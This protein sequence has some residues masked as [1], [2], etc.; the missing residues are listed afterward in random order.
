MGDDLVYLDYAATAGRRPPAVAAAIADFLTNNGTTPGRGGHRL[1]IDAARAM[2][3]CRQSLA[4]LLHIPGD[5]GRIAFQHNATHALNS[6]LY[7]LLRDGDVVVTTPFEHNSVVRPLHA[8]EKTRR[9]L[10][11]IIPGDRSGALD[12]VRAAR[13]LEGARLLVVTGA[14]NVLGT[15]TPLNDL[16]ALARGAGAL[17][18]VDAAQAAGSLPLDV[19]ALGIDALAITGHK[20]LLGP[21]GVGALWVRAGVDP[22]PLLRGGTG[23]DSLDIDMPRALP[24]RLEAGTLNAPGIIGLGAALGWLLEQDLTAM[25]AREMAL[26]ARLHARLEAIDG[27][28]VLSPPALDGVPIVTMTAEQLDPAQLAGRLDREHGVLVRPGLHCAPGV[29]RLLGT[30]HTGAVRFSLGWASTEDDVERAAHAVAAVLA[31]TAA[32]VGH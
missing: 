17:V 25:R 32:G 12:L 15:H 10:P 3:R 4:R 19:A 11:R 1:A 23:G 30:E 31:S 26:K 27:V 13:M 18:V 9:I 8:I 5:P 2:L 7:G 16:V 20:A 21:Q 24:D 29:H 28:N 6:A 14:S 22:E